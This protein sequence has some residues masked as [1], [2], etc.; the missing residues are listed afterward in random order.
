MPKNKETV[1]LPLPP[2]VTAQLIGTVLSVKGPKGEVS[3]DFSK[4][5]IGISVTGNEVVLQ[6]FGGRRRDHAVLNTC[7]S[8]VHN[9]FKGVTEGF[10]YRLKVVYA[11]F[12]VTVKVKGD[13]VHIE[14]FYGERFPRIAKVVGPLTKV[15]VEGDDVIVSGPSI[16]EVSQTA[17]NIESATRIKERDARVFLD[18][19]YIYERKK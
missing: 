4:I 10:E 9:M 8:H 3:R 2:G 18:G 5:P 14:N 6:A 12:P 16:D 19:V 1:S 15:T 11:H 7:K 17:A 13:E